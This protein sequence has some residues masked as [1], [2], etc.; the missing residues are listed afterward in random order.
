MS[1]RLALKA[2][3]TSTAPS[4][5]KEFDAPVSTIGRAESNDIT[6]QDP[7]RLVSSKHGEIRQ[8]SEQHYVF[9]DL[10]STNGSSLNGQCLEGGKEYPLSTHDELAIGEYL[11]EFHQTVRKPVSV[12]REPDWDATVCL[13]PSVSN[14]ETVVDQLRTLY[15]QLGQREPQERAPLL[16]ETLREAVDGLERAEAE[17]LLSLVE[18]T[19]PDPEF[20]QEQ[21]LNPSVRRS[22]GSFASREDI[23]DS[24]IPGVERI[25]SKYLSTTPGFL[26][27]EDKVET[28]ERVDQ[29]LD[30][31]LES[32]AD[33]VKA[34]KKFQEEMEVEVTRIFS[35]EQNPIKWAE[36]SQEIGAYLFDPQRKD[37]DAQAI[38]YLREALKDLALQP[39]GV[40][41]GFRECVR[42]LLNQL[43]PVMFETE[44]RDATP[45]I[46]PLTLGLLVKSSAWKRFS[47]KHHTLLEEEA[48]TVKNLLGEEF[49][50]G[51][52]RVYSQQPSS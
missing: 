33:A 14:Y 38:Q 4:L 26:S 39:I 7:H 52:L 50:K 21:I 30:V 8:T 24:E 37:T 9:V 32:L 3:P 15:R 20:Q 27:P 42:G 25:V 40:M 43:D 31:F 41:A 44:A 5:E 6:L 28:S 19:F 49:A 11:L 29:I 35:R 47:K 48:K 2:G 34:R 45:H 10:G 22:V 51:Y 12:A 36:S 46:G 16:L 17:R 18:A 23:T 1:F 13:A